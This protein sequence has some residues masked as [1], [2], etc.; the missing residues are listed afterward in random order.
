[1]DPTNRARVGGRSSGLPDHQAKLNRE[2]ADFC[3]GLPLFWAK[4]SDRGLEC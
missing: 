2:A 1:M 3:R 4:G